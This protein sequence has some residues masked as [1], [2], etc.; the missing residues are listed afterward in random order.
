MK[1]EDE[2][3]DEDEV[4]TLQPRVG[5]HENDIGF[6]EVSYKRLGRH[7]TPETFTINIHIATLFHALRS[8]L[9]SLRYNDNSTGSSER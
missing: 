6:H 3:E 1:D 7:L 5:F 2:Y 4:R 9:C 8:V